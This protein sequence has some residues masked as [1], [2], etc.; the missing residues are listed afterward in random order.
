MVIPCYTMQ[1]CKVVRFVRFVRR[2]TSFVRLVRFVRIRTRLARRTDQT[3]QK[4]RP[5]GPAVSTLFCQ[6]MI[7]KKSDQNP[8][9]FVPKRR[10]LEDLFA[11]KRRPHLNILECIFYR[12]MRPLSVKI[13]IIPILICP[14][15]HQTAA[16]SMY[17]GLIKT[18]W[19]PYQY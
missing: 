13:Q 7:F 12:Q 16:N 19:N 9:T 17:I 5:D 1:H 15:D 2:R 11:W 8:T 6:T 4:V 3:D 14:S 18:T 10:P